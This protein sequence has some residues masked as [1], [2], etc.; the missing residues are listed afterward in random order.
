MS[1]VRLIHGHVLDELKRL[2]DKS[3]RSCVTSPPYYNLRDYGGEPVSW[4]KHSY[5]I[6]AGM[7]FSMGFPARPG[8]LGAEVSPEE[9]IGRLVL[10]FS[11]VYRVLTD[12]GTLW[13]NLGDSYARDGGAGRGGRDFLGMGGREKR[14]EKL[15][16][17]SGV[18]P[19]ELLGIP[20]RT[21]FAL[22]AAGWKLRM[23][24]IWHKPNPMPESVRDRPTKAHEYLFLFA[25][26]ERYHCDMSKIREPFADDRQGR[27]GAKRQSERNRG[28][29]TDG[30]TKP[31]GIDPSTNGGKNKRSVWTVA[32]VG[33]PGAH[34]ATFPEKLIEPCI[35]AGSQTE[36]VRCDCEEPIY[37][38]I[39]E[40]VAEDPSMEVG[41]AGMSRPRG[42]ESGVRIVTRR[43]QRHHAIEMKQ[44]P[45]RAEMQR[46][47]G[48]PFDHYIRTDRIGARA[49]PPDLRDL[50]MAEGWIT[51]APPCDH[52]DQPTDIILDPFCGSGTTGRVAV[53]HGRSF[54]GIDNNADY[55][56]M[57]EK[58]TTEDL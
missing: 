13:L 6:M 5:R 48:S 2:P 18:G 35:L 26:N 53:K 37:S 21:A 1:T 12:D 30:L 40:E 52:E 39:G 22:Q 14:M 44:S 51:D 56:L 24:I 15:P 42:E 41:R 7:P 29:R 47:A 20:W 32:T 10:V 50:F 38:P 31:N 45:F 58:R 9:Y 19:K 25:K 33:F 57:A 8:I 4:P 43:E 28:G 27:D 55:L 11:E 23:D 46:I 3:I 17:E 54:I 49:L 16:P 34:F 36:G